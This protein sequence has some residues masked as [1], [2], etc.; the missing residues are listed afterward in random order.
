MTTLTLTQNQKSKVATLYDWAHGTV[1]IVLL[2]WALLGT[3]LTYVL[4]FVVGLGSFG[5]GVWPVILLGLILSWA[6]F[7]LVGRLLQGGRDRLA[8]WEKAPTEL[9]KKW[10]ALDDQ[11]NREGRGLI[12][13]MLRG[14]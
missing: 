5:L 2:V 14:K 7:F 1:G 8:K 10:R 3:I 11:D 6:P 4:T 12:R 13:K 9:Q